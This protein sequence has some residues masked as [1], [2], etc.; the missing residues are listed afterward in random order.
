MGHLH[1]SCPCRVLQRAARLAV[2]I[3][4]ELFASMADAPDLT[5][6]LSTGTSLGC[7][8]LMKQACTCAASS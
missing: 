5:Q 2:C 7:F 1:N 3:G 8:A 4:L 6:S